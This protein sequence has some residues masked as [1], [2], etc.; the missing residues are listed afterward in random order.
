[1]SGFVQLMVAA[2]DMTTDYSET[3][4]NG[5]SKRRTTSVQQTKSMPP[6]TLPIEIVH[7]EPP[8]SE[9]LSTLDNGQPACPQITAVCTK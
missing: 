2:E 4:N 5:L 7:L 8:R 6:I 9:H 3:S 1:M